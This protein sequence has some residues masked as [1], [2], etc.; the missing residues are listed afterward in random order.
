MSMKD[1]FLRA[2]T[3]YDEVYEAGKKAE[4]NA[5]WDACQENGNRTDYDGAFARATWNDNNFKPKYDMKPTTADSM[6]YRF[7]GNGF[8]PSMDLATRLEKYGVTLDFSECEYFNYCFQ[9]AQIHRVGTIDVRKSVRTIE[10]MFSNC[11]W[12][13]T[14]DKLIVSESNAFDYWCFINADIRN[15]DVEGV[16][17]SDLALQTCPLTKASFE[18]VVKALSSSASGKTVTFNKSAKE[19]AFTDSEWDA[20]TAKK[21]NWKFYFE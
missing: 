15:I 6:F 10:A 18:N 1:K 16:I 19:S 21:S 4:W 17:G 11:Y 13:H 20:L 3:D 5:F 7:N 12:L 14:V 2:K 9:N 8:T